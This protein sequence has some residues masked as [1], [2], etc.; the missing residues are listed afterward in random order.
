MSRPKNTSR[1]T[2]AVLRY[3][4]HLDDQ[5]VHAYALTKDTGI[6]GGTLSPLLRRLEGLHY[7][8]SRWQMLTLGPPRREYRLT[9]EGF[10]FLRSRV[11]AQGN[12]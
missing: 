9:L 7:L 5:W 10:R 6:K 2:L 12:P 8:E 1:Q 3:L 4:S 11:Q